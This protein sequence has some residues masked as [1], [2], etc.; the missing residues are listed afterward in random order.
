MQTAKKQKENKNL[1]F[2]RFSNITRRSFRN[3]P[4]ILSIIL[5]VILLYL[6]IGPLVSMVQSSFTLH[7]RDALFLDD[8]NAGDFT[9]Y[10]LVRTFLSNMKN[11]LFYKPFL[12]TLIVIFPMS[13][14]AVL[15]GGILA[16][17]VVRT[18][19]PGRRFFARIAITPYIL[20]SWT[21]A[22]AW[23]NIFKNRTI[24]GSAGIL[25]YLGITPP[26]WM[27]FGPLPIIIVMAL[28][29]YTFSF[30]LIGSG[31]RE[32]DTRLEESASVLGADQ[33]TTIRKIV[34]PLIAPA[35]L[36]G[37]VLTIARGVGSFSAPAFLGRPVNFQVLSTKLFSNL[38]TG[39]PGIAYLLA[40]VMI[41]LAISFIYI[42]QK[43]VG[44]RKGFVTITGKAA[45]KNIVKLGKAT[46]LIMTLV[47]LFFTFV[48]F[49]PIIVLAIETF[50]KVPGDYSLS[51]FTLQYWIGKGDP[52]I[53]SGTPGVLRSPEMW[54][55]TW[56][57]L[58]LGLLSSF[59]C[60][61][62]G[63]L[64]GYTVVR[65]RGTFLSKSLDQVSFLPYLIPSIAFGAIYLSLFAKPRGFIPSLYGTFA[66]L[67]LVTTVKN[68]PFAT[69]AGIS[70]MMQLGHEIEEAGIIAGAGWFTRMRRL[71]MP[72]QKS[73]L[74]SGI[75]LPMVSAMRELSLLIILI[76]PG[77]HLLTTLTFKYTDY[78]YYSISNA[79]LLINIFVVLILCAIVQK[80]TKSDLSKGLGG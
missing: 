11:V 30:L 47:I 20:P 17:L 78:G 66:L 76:T 59:F 23:I 54:Q 12:N 8:E 55:A 65:L 50:V 79:L 9:T 5:F 43:I 22:L 67:I 52:H 44:T 26:T 75:L 56:N 49:V 74:L 34:F 1:F 51:N 53:L 27:S 28:H 77:T 64:I 37:W 72:L 71:I 15:I 45:T 19:L 63:L 3:P 73:N 60:A 4:F 10:Y 14:I 62:A 35:V 36:S 13:A 46:P 6:I 69:R 80:I 31:L 58:K 39:S 38:Q 33:K 7:P 70:G 16:W 61:I 40:L 2:K 24:G 32:I 48:V 41:L 18:D 25:E 21:L 42:N 57:S 68:L 29:Y